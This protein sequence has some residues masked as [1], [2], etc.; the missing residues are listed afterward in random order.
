[1]CLHHPQ[2][3]RASRDR[4][5]R[6]KEKGKNLFS[7]NYT[8]HPHARDRL[9]S[10]RCFTPHITS[11]KQRMFCVCYWR[12]RCQRH[13][14]FGSRDWGCAT[15]RWRLES[16]LIHKNI[17]SS[18]PFWISSVEETSTK[19]MLRIENIDLR[20]LAQEGTLGITHRDPLASAINVS[21][22]LL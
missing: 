7:I 6:K 16:N 1:M 17:R 14:H 20:K 8:R 13:C 11:K 19:M 12:I 9:A 10:G 2:T 21:S 5:S 18:L 3:S 15:W 4:E 22:S